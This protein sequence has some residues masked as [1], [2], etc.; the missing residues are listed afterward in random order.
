[1]TQA[2]LDFAAA[3]VREHVPASEPIRA[4]QIGNFVGVSL[5]YVSATLR[6]LHPDSVVVS[7]DPNI[8]HRAIADPQ[9]HV[10]ALLGHFDLLR[11]NAVV[12]GY[13]LEQSSAPAPMPAA[14][15]AR[16]WPAA[17]TSPSALRTQERPHRIRRTRCHRTR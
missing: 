16:R 8:T 17:A 5:S 6:A 7:M 12:T 14:S 4:L 9:S 11:N 10:L 1:M 15:A 13:S 2:A 3:I